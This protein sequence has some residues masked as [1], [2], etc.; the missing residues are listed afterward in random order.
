MRKCLQTPAE[1][2][3]LRNLEIL[4]L[5]PEKIDQNILEV[6]LLDEHLFERLKFTE[7][8]DRFIAK[9]ISYWIQVSHS[10]SMDL[11]A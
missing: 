8:T 4:A 7:T 6:L 5:F 3:L 9:D 1:A 2:L 11:V 10:P